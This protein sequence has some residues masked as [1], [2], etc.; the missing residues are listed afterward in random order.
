MLIVNISSVGSALALVL[1]EGVSLAIPNFMSMMIDFVNK[2]DMSVHLIQNGY[3]LTA[4][5]FVAQVLVALTTALNLTINRRIDQYLQSLL[6]YAI[7]V[8]SFK[9]SAKSRAEFPE[10][11]IMTMINNDIRQ[12]STLFTSLSQVIII[13]VTITFTLYFLFRYIGH[14]LWYGIGVVL[15]SGLISVLTGP[16]VGKF[17]GE[18]IGAQDHRLSTI[19]DMLMGIRMVKFRV[20]EDFFEKKALDARSVQIAALR[21]VLTALGVTQSLI[22]SVP[23]IVA[24][25]TFSIYS[26]SNPMDPAVLFPSISFFGL[27]TQPLHLIYNVIMAVSQGIISLRRVASILEA[28]ELDI[29]IDDDKENVG[30]VCTKGATWKWIVSDDEAAPK[31]Q[32][33]EEKESKSLDDKK[34]IKESDNEESESFQLKNVSLDI[35]PGTTIGLIGT[36]GMGKS[37]LFSALLREMQLVS[38]EVNIKGKIAYCSQK[39]WIMAGTVEQ[40][41]L[42]GQELDTERL[43]LAIKSAGMTRDLEILPDGVK[44]QLGENGIS[45]SGG[46]KAR[47][48]LARAFYS[49]SDIYFLDCPL[50]ALDSKVSKEVF[51]NGILQLLENK[52]VILATHN[53][54]LLPQLDEVMVIDEGSIIESG[55]YEDLRKNENSRLS[56]LI[57]N[58]DEHAD[59]EHQSEDEETKVVTESASEKKEESNGPFEEEEKN[60]GGINFETYNR[61]AKAIGVPLIII[62][63]LAALSQLGASI[64]SPLW[65]AHWSSSTNSG[66]SFYL[67]W[68]STIGAFN[69]LAFLILFL[70]AILIGIKLVKY[71]HDG[72]LKGLLRAPVAFFDAN[73]V[74]RMINR[75]STDVMQLDFSVPTVFLNLIGNIIGCLVLVILVSQAS[76]YLVGVF[77]LLSIPCYFLFYLY[78]PANLELKRLTAI[79]RSPLDSWTSETFTGLATIRAYNSTSIWIKRQQELI[80]LA[81]V[82][83]FMY[84]S[85]SIWLNLRLSLLSVFITVTVMLVGTEASAVGLALA[86]TSDISQAVSGLLTF[87]GVFEAEFNSIERLLHYTLDLPKEPAALLP[88][89]PKGDWPAKGAVQLEN[90]SIAYPSKPDHL[91]IKNL[92]LDVEPGQN[93]GVVGR[94]GSGK[95][96]LV[97]SLF[98]IINDYTGKIIID[99]IE[100]SQLGISTLRRGLYMIPQEPTLFEGTIRS[101]IDWKGIY[102][103]DKLWDALDI[104]GLKSYVSGLPDGLDHKVDG[105]GGNMSVGQKQLLCIVGAVLEN[106]KVVVFDESTSALDGEADNV[107]Q[108]LISVNLKSSTVITIAHRLNTIASYDRVLVL[109]QGNMVEFDSPKN[110]LLN[111]DSLFYELSEATGPSNF[112]IIKS[113]ASIE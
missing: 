93:V 41:I 72:A 26:L 13:P 77:F 39:P 91:V 53:L 63:I 65:L 85:L 8:K 104:C 88:T 4:I 34:D 109:D 47:V 75:M 20:M 2:K 17:I 51:N 71:L 86:Y 48:A 15:F 30:S 87:L 69:V 11:K 80:D 27:L 68:Y 97:S 44:T 101:N 49:D 23:T 40:N 60:K 37:S 25:V 36:V 56:S 107:I 16:I 32:A 38:G 112:A 95:S 59:S 103:D 9:L 22:G 33:E 52:T 57:S 58:Y 92:T 21:K 55:T 106:P 1:T 50:A 90:L 67:V 10:G 54:S 5:V 43:D 110:L 18:F 7:Y 46:Q 81:L 98:R 28:E 113:L 14:S 76:I 19:R 61:V 62:S 105:E 42:F 100:I 111:K 24:V 89:D 12:I 78:K 31:P 70:V 108:K 73:P 84:S 82:P 35:K 29:S 94:T 102:S 96:T 6:S 64:A 45:L 83:S 3:T 66:D 74:G 99:G 79:S